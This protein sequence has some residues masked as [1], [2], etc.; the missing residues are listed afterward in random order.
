M[1]KISY[2]AIFALVGSLI[3]FQGC[4]KKPVEQLAK[5]EEAIKK[6][7]DADAPLRAS[8]AFSKADSKLTEGKQLISK[9]KYKNA[10]PVLEECVALANKATADAIAHKE[11]QT[12]KIIEDKSIIEE[13][14]KE[15]TV[16]RGDC[17]W[18]IAKKY[19]TNPYQ[20][21]TIYN[22]NKDK[23]SNPDLIYPKQVLTIPQ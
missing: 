23:I 8:D 11:A 15:Y 19:Y 21:T 20:W 14:I 6:A 1:Y 13:T 9:K 2:I 7:I 18:F 5:A 4:T 12:Q 3:F 22:E 10:I 16:V 17:L